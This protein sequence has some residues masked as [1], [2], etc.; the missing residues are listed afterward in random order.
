MYTLY[1]QI[2]S[3]YAEVEVKVVTISDMETVCI[4]AV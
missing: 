4:K 2:Y 1:K 3:N